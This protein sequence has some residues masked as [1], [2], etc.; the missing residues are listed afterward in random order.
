MEHLSH[1]IHEELFLVEAVQ[2][3]PVGV[4]SEESTKYTL[5]IV[6]NSLDEADKKLLADI[7][8][9]IKLDSEEITFQDAISAISRRW[10]VFADAL[11]YEGNQ[12]Y[13]T[14]KRQINSNTIIL[15]HPLKALRESKQEKGALWLILKEE[16][17]L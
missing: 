4:K 17:G 15:A 12:W 6:A 1:F 3:I 8:R 14:E 7:L 5:G 11:T 13:P 16:F 10:V 2:S 9:A